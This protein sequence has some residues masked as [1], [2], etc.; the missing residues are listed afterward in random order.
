MLSATL[1]DQ[2]AI[3]GCL[4]PFRTQVS[5]T[6]WVSGEDASLTIFLNG[7]DSSEHMFQLIQNHIFACNEP[8]ICT[9]PHRFPVSL[10]LKGTD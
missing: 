7:F 2:T 6:V 5:A 9:Y 4:E 1:K 10:S 8:Q 3:S